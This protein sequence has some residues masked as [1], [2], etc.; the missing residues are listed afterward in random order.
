MEYRVEIKASAIKEL[1]K[2]QPDVGKRILNALD[3]LASDPKPVQSRKLVE[4]NSS[5]RLSLK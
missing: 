3:A 1:S 2:L 5:Y 4:T